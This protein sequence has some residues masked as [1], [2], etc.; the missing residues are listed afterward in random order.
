M[1]CFLRKKNLES[2][3]IQLVIYISIRKINLL[4]P[5]LVFFIIFN[6]FLLSIMKQFEKYNFKSNKL[7]FFLS[8]YLFTANLSE[9]NLNKVK[10][11]L[12][13]F[14][15]FLIIKASTDL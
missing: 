5:L 6:L 11:M 12:L 14:S 3:E 13:F 9:E 8:C 10:I 15:L 2:Q 7:F 1:V 4:F